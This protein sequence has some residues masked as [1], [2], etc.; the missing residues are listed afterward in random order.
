MSETNLNNFIKTLTFIP[1][2]F[3]V[4]IS[5]IVVSIILNIFELFD[6]VDISEVP[7][8][9]EISCLFIIF[10]LALLVAYMVLHIVVS[11]FMIQCRREMKKLQKDAL[12][13]TRE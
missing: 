2:L 1:R 7:D 8:T 12:S 11:I 9:F 13:F 3:M 6:I 4:Y 10:I 5:L